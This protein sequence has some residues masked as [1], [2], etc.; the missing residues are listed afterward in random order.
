MKQ[1]MHRWGLS[2]AGYITI[3]VAVFGPALL[4]G[5][6]MLLFGDDIHRTYYFFREFFSVWFAKGIIPWWNPYLFS[7]EP[8][9]ANPIVNI[10]Y[11]GNWLF[12]IL[13]LHVA[14]SWYLAFHVCWAMLGMFVLLRSMMGTNN[15]APGNAAWV[16]GV[17]FGLSG[18]FMARTYAGHADMIAAASWMPWVVW[19]FYQLVRAKVGISW[20]SRRQ[21]PDHGSVHQG[22]SAKAV[23]AL[24]TK[25]LPARMFVI[26]A[27][28]F[29]MQ[30]FAG[31]QTMAF[32][33]VIVVSMVAVIVSIRQK[34][35]WPCIKAIGAGVTGLLL[36]AVQIV[37]EQEFFRASIRT[38]PLPY[39]WISYGSLS[40]QS[41]IQLLYP[42]YFGNQAT[43]H[44]P[45][46]N[47]IEHSAFVGIGGLVL[48]LAGAL[49]GVS[50]F[51]RRLPVRF[52]GLTFIVV[53]FFGVW[54][55]LGPNAPIDLQYIFWKLIPMYHYL[56]IPPRHLVLV[57]FGLAGLAGIGFEVISR[58]FKKLRYLK[59]LITG[60]IV[61]EMVWFAHGFIGLRSVPEA[62]HDQELIALLKQD[63]EP[64]RLL[65]DFGVWLPPRDSLDFDSVMPYDIF[66]AT[67]YDPSI[68]RNYYDYLAR[69]TG[70]MGEKAV[71]EQDV[72]VPYLTPN[73]AGALDR[74]NVK[75]ILVPQAFDPFVANS[76]YHL[77]REDVSRGYRLYE[78]TTVKP[79]FYFR[80]PAN[81]T[82]QVT[83]YTPNQI[84]LTVDAKG[85]GELLSSEV[86]YPG[87]EAFID[88]KKVDITVSDGVFRTLFVLSGKHTITYLYRPTIFVIGLG[89]TVVTI[90]GLA[91]WVK[92]TYKPS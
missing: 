85:T 20:F 56:R 91:L 5:K 7:G 31:Y 87:W 59:I 41:L 55:S 84:T 42:F 52:L 2:I 60:I 36:A 43:Y 58:S 48:A 92:F 35:F 81:G 16:G 25:R 28:V 23:T 34:S 80:D 63:K 75:Y 51:S 57:V 83:S 19:A 46:P 26:A 38:Y 3:V 37:P 77:L 71:L 49:V 39:S 78:N 65:Q 72:Q 9:M 14:Y 50:W 10:W 61:A 70:T 12:I 82:A 64:F 33:T 17:I 76:R 53:T 6:G 4:P 62:R 67:G 24:E 54:I 1:W 86:Q 15:R 21:G 13:P 45:P 44:G 18:F 79:R 29:A 66:S 40:W 11:P 47:F 30:L 27:F 74:L 68:L 88:G 73:E 22:S 32:F 90:A 89:I 8:F 69:A